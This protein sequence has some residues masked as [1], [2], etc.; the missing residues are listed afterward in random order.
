MEFFIQLLADGLVRGSNIILLALGFSLALSVSDVFH[1]AHGGIYTLA[2]YV[3]YQLYTLLGV[4]L[5][6][7]VFGAFV[8]C[9]LV[10]TG[11]ETLVYRPLRIRGTDR[12]LM[13][14]V[15]MGIL[16]I[17]E[18]TIAMIWGSSTLHFQPLA[19]LAP[20]STIRIGPVV[21]S[22]VRVLTFLVCI[23]IYAIV[24]FYFLR[25]TRTGVAIRALISDRRM[26]RVVG[27]NQARIT[28]LCF[29]LAQ[30]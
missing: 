26:A 22:Q 25:R 10:G 9:I 2:A 15:S 5:G 18:A 7:A 30:S 21:M 8:V 24:Y 14:L 17:M 29:I 19:T 12:L 11:V 16:F 27:V 1:F 6:L 4:N 28:M 23:G 3:V 20:S 13:L